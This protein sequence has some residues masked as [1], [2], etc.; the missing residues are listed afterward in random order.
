[1]T[2]LKFTFEDGS[3]ALAHYG[4]LGMKW[5]V[6]KDGKPQ[7]FQYGSKHRKR[8]KQAAGSA[9]KFVKRRTETKIDRLKANANRSQLS[10]SELNY[11]IDRLRRERQLRELTR[12]EVTPGRNVVHKIL[13]NTGTKVIGG[14]AAAVGTYAVATLLSGGKFDWSEATER[15]P[16]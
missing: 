12:S 6:R 1:M 5:G 7:S 14:A 11:R 15:I 13:S 2:E 16:Q 10:D 9:G 8:V 3:E 4:V